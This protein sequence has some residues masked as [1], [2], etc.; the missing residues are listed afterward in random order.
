MLKTLEQKYKKSFVQI[1]LRWHIQ[2]GVIPVI[3]A[4]NPVHQK[5]NI[6]IFD[7][8]LSEEDMKLIDSIN[9][10]SRLRY[11]PDNCDFTIL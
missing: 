8:E 4:M 6:D 2:N 9:L 1:I 5:S 3:K 10:D 7:F 11:N